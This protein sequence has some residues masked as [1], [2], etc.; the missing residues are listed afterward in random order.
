MR[1][2][3]VRLRTE[4][5]A[6]P[7]QAPI[8][9]GGMAPGDALPEALRSSDGSK[10]TA[11]DS[12]D[13]RRDRGSRHAA[14]GPEHTPVVRRAVPTA[15]ECRRLRGHRGRERIRPPPRRSRPPWPPDPTSATSYAP[16]KG[17]TG[18][19]PDLRH[20]DGPGR[21]PR[22]RD[23][24]RAHGHP[25][26]APLRPR[27]LPHHPARR[28][29]RPRIPPGSSE[30]HRNPGHDE[31]TD[32]RLLE[33]ID[34]M[35]TA[36]ASSRSPCSSAAG[37]STATCSHSW[38][39]TASSSAATRTTRSAGSTAASTCPGA[40]WSIST[41][42]SASSTSGRRAVRHAGRRHL[43]P[44]PRRGHHEGR[45]SREALLRSFREQY[46]E[47]RGSPTPCLNRHPG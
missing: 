38:R 9:L 14:T 20:L 8:L 41:C 45:R 13:V 25:P 17:L 16:T 37:I 2:E 29:E 1:T 39:A 21:P 31:Q 7:A 34:W 42:T 40:G 35:P 5:H 28:R 10:P 18:S 6:P 47:I 43:P 22:T 15:H 33:R 11:H 32:Q 46:L 19:G 27:G 36:T 12:R 44:V 3:Y 26:G 24:R 4:V 23:R 30:Q